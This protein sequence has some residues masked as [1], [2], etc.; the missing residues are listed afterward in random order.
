MSPVSRQTAQPVD[1]RNGQLAVAPPTYKRFFILGSARTGTTLLR[2][3]LESHSQIACF[4]EWRSYISLATQEY[5]A[6]EGVR[7][8]GFKIPAWTEQL[9]DEVVSDPI[10]NDRSVQQF[11]RGDRGIFMLRDVREVVASMYTI[12]LIDQLL[13]TVQAKLDQQPAFSQKYARELAVVST[14]SHP[15]L[16]LGALYWKDKTLA[17]FDYVRAGLPILGVRYEDLTAAPERQLRRIVR[18]LDL[19]WE[20]GLLDHPSHPHGELDSTG[21]AIAGTDPGR[22]IDAASIRSWERC[23]SDEQV[24]AIM[25]VAGDLNERIHTAATLDPEV[26]RI[27]SAWSA[28]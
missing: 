3:V 8:L 6:P 2:L 27:L 17:L 19:P 18:F 5:E 25:A 26:Q 28:D 20:D 12:S 16:A 13:D 22:A 21:M 24:A 1:A 7:Y 11:Y 9:S 23:F 10:T 4:D 15:R 14:S